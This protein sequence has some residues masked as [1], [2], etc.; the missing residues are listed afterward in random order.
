MVFQ[1]AFGSAV[2]CSVRGRACT[3]G[4]L[5]VDDRTVRQGAHILITEYPSGSAGGGMCSLFFRR[6][7]PCVR[8]N[9]AALLLLLF[10]SDGV[11]V[12]CMASRVQLYSHILP[13]LVSLFELMFVIFLLCEVRKVGNILVARKAGLVASRLLMWC[14]VPS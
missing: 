12:G 11:M 13:V 7:R 10:T 3:S 8:Q 6:C 4:V 5:S 9:G 14:R 2:P 1:S